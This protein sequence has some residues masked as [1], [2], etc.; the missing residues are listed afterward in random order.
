MSNAP[1]LLEGMLTSNDINL[2]VEL[3]KQNSSDKELARTWQER[4]VVEVMQRPP[5]GVTPTTSVANAAQIMIERDLNCLP[6]VAYES[7]E[8]SS[9]EAEQEMF[10]ILVGILT[11]SDMLLALAHL[12]GTF[13]PG[14]QLLLPLPP[15]DVTPLAKMLLLAA[16]LHIQ[17]S[18][19]VVASLKEN[20]PH[21]ATVHISTIYPA[22]L[23]KRLQENGIQY[24][25][26]ERGDTHVAHE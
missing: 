10:P 26:A 25:F 18:S 23:F 9:E 1:L 7:A 19:I 14:M 2:A 15:G 11:R 17:V 3:D 20:V 8:V 12:T 16:E 22:P 5:F 24:S 13:E 6:I 4:H 21:V